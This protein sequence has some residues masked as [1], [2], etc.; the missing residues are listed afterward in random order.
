MNDPTRHRHLGLHSATG[1]VIT[2]ALLM[3]AGIPVASPARAGQEVI[4]DGV[5]HIANSDEPAEG[6]QTLQLEELWRVGGDD[7]ADTIFGVIGQILEDDEN[8]YL[9]DTQLSEIKV[10]TREGLALDIIGREGDGPGEFRGPADI[11]LLPDGTIGV[12][13]G[14]PGK[15]IKLA[16]DGT[17]AGV[18]NLGDPAQ[19]SFYFMNALNQGNGTVVAGGVQQSIDQTAGTM[20]RERFLSSIGQDGLRDVTYVSVPG[21]LQ[22]NALRVDEL[23]IIDGPDRRFDVTTT[24]L[25]IVGIPR[26]EYEVSIFAADGTLER[27]FTREYDSWPRSERAA[28]IWQRIMENIRDNMV[29]G[30]PVSW[31]DTEPD[32]E[33]L[34]TADNGSIWILNSRSMWEPPE[35][36]FTCYDVFTPEG[37]YQKEVRIVCPGDATVDLLFYAGGDRAFMVTD[38]WDAALGQFGGAGDDESDEDVESMKVICYRVGT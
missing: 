10:F 28:G 7:D 24:G 25:T 29:P 11:C 35:G 17:P 5:V 18:W 37:H 26:N 38:F 16:L 20:T 3:L 21:I 12:L 32:I 9:L 34:Q 22:L 14:F 4:V 8:I 27:V 19:G 33:F 15:V 36:V 2:A 30:A 1:L 13:Q 31:E 6:V 23:E